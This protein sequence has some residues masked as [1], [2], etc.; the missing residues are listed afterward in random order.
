MERKLSVLNIYDHFQNHKDFLDRIVSS[1]NLAD[2][3]LIVVGDLNL[4]LLDNELWGLKVKID[5]PASYFLDIFEQVRLVDVVPSAMNPTWS[6]GRGGSAHIAKCLDR[7][8]MED[9]LSD[10]LGKYWT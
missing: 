2:P 10:L 5:P 9:S 4:T 7:F 1:G 3:S 6:N 8:L